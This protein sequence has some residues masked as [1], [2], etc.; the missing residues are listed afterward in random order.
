MPTTGGADGSVE[1]GPYVDGE[2]RGHWV[3]RR[4]D[5]SVVEIRYVR[6]KRQ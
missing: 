3:I 2:R 5:G 1:E 6:G 4:A